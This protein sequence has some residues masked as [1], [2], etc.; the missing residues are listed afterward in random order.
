MSAK[1]PPGLTSAGMGDERENKTGRTGR[2]RCTCLHLLH[3][4]LHHPC[5]SLRRSLPRYLLQGRH[6]SGR[7]II[8]HNALNVSVDSQIY[9]QRA[10][11]RRTYRL[12][13]SQQQVN[14]L[15]LQ[16]M[17]EDLVVVRYGSDLTCCQMPSVAEVLDRSD[18]SNIH[19]LAVGRQTRIA[20]QYMCLRKDQSEE[21]NGRNAR[22][23]R[24]VLSIVAH[25][26]LEVAGSRPVLDRDRHV[27][28]LGG[29]VSYDSDQS[30]L[31]GKRVRINVSQSVG[32][33]SSTSPP[34]AVAFQPQ[35]DNSRAPVHL[36][37]R[38]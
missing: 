22:H 33:T 36:L 4:L 26:K 37:S 6:S 32:R 2:D 27:R 13:A 35:R 12:S 28:R 19:V 30:E 17:E 24:I 3:H 25:P 14:V 29:N 23:S 20:S 5:C 16:K 34:P 38:T 7:A 10:E 21:G 1:S 15:G 8:V 9:L 18:D 11:E 31:D